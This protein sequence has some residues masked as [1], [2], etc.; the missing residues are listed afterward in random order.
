M[1]ENEPQ[2]GEWLPVSTA[3]RRLGISP[4]A[5]RG[6]IDRGTVQW[7][8]AGNTG[9]LVLIRPEDVAAEEDRD[10]SQDELDRLRDELAGERIGRARAEERAAALREALDREQARADRLEA[11]LRRPWWRKLIGR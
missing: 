7:K 9:K 3:A 2:D 11:D 1:G 5:L 6:R 10:A 8:Q 4:R